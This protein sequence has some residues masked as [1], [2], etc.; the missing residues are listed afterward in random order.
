KY[1]FINMKFLP[2]YFHPYFYGGNRLP[3]CIARLWRGRISQN[4]IGRYCG[5]N[6][7]DAERWNVEKMKGHS[8]Q[9]PLRWAGNYSLP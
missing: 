7:G 8:C 2:M 5:E 9:W 6:R 4:G 3:L 1:N